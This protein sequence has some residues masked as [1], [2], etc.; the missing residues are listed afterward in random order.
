MVNQELLDYIVRQ[1]DHG[2]SANNIKEALLKAGWEPNAVA[3]GI[4]ATEPAPVGAPLSAAAARVEMRPAAPTV[5]ASPAVVETGPAVQ[6]AQGPTMSAQPIPSTQNFPVAPAMPSV[7]AAPV[8]PMAAQPQTAAVSTS[9]L[10][11]PESFPPVVHPAPMTPPLSVLTGQPTGTVAGGAPLQAAAVSQQPL[12]QS[13]APQGVQFPSANFMPK[14]QPAPATVPPVGVTAVMPKVE[15]AVT[16][17]SHLGIII[18]GSIAVVVLALG[19]AFA[20]FKYATPTAQPVVPADQPVVRD[21]TIPAANPPVDNTAIIPPTTDTGMGPIS[22]P[23][24][25]ISTSTEESAT[26]TLA[27]T[28]SAASSST[29]TPTATSTTKTK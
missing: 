25:V 12:V 3:E 22:F 5:E 14:V 6:G 1:R 24:S 20:Y 29:T 7:Q 10:Q 28:S 15:A 26:T 27:A 17:K 8:M 11:K 9:P 4:A 23:S 16:K 18:S 13:P 19:G 21:V 2:A